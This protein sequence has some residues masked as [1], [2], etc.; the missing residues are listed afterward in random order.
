MSINT[1]NVLGHDRFEV[2]VARLEVRDARGGL[3][4]GAGQDSVTVGAD[5]LTV[6]SPAGVTVQ[7]AAQTPLVK[8]PPSKPLV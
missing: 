1:T 2:N 6:V 4:L 3:L 8:A 5:T 7:A